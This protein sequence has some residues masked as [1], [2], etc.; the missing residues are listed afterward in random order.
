MEFK[1]Y[2]HTKEEKKISDFWI[3]KGLFKP[4][5]GKLNK[6]FAEIIRKKTINLVER[7]K[8]REYYS[9]KS[10]L[11]MGAKNFSWTAALY[12]DFKLNRS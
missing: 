5:K 2:N 10:G 6:K 8:F 11:G 4:K 7:K 3:K 12:L 1:K 9:C